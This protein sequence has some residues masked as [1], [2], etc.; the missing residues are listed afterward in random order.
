MEHI[1][2]EAGLERHAK[3]PK[4]YFFPTLTKFLFFQKIFVKVFNTKFHENRSSG[5]SADTRGQA[6]GYA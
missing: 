6:E 1:K 3:F 4:G 5:I 2:Y